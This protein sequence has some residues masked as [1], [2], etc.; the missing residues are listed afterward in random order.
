MRKSIKTRTVLFTAAALAAAVALGV[1]ARVAA[2]SAPVAA[3]T[4]T[5]GL[6]ADAGRQRRWAIILET[7]IRQG[8]LSAAAPASTTI[9]TGDWTVTVSGASAAG[10][11]V[12]CQLDKAH[13]VGSGFGTVDAKDLAQLEQNLGK[14]FWVTYQRDGAAK[15]LHFPREMGDDV[16]NFLELLVTGSE[17]VHATQP[18]P[19]W[20]ATERDGAG[21]YFAAYQQPSSSQ[22][23]KR[24]LRYV[25]LD[26]VAASGPAPIGVS[27]ENAETRFTLDQDGLVSEL[28]GHESSSLDSKMGA[29]ALGVEITLQMQRALA[30]NDRSLIGSLDRARAG[31]DSGPVVTQRA[32]AE[33]LQARYDTRLIKDL[34]LH[35]V[36]EGLASGHPDDRTEPALEAIFRRRPSDIPAALA[37]VRQASPGAAKAVLQALGVAGTDAAQS[38]LG[39]VATDGHA[40]AGLRVAA[41]GGFVQTKRPSAA[42]ISTLVGLMDSTEPGIQ[43][44]AL[45]MAGSVGSSGHDDDPAGTARIEAELLGRYAR[46]SGP[47][48]LDLLAA[49]GNLATPAIVTPI[50]QALNNS[51]ADLRASAV[52]ALRKVKDPAAERLISATILGDHDPGV[53]AAAIFAT[54]FRPIGTFVEPLTR[55]V[56]TDPVDYVRT[57]AIN[58]VANHIDASPL[59][60]AALVAAATDD[61]K[62]GIRRLAR[63]ALRPRAALQPVR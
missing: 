5:V 45:Y 59:I 11:E 56:R 54:T 1:R 50:A 40:P 36:L 46:C 19:Q 21:T 42:T 62:P 47:L 18:S 38:A 39:A 14:R 32:P 9:L 23:I 28:H 33:E 31:L 20:T 49:L 26:G 13:I 48:C 44:Q 53:R 17:L 58:S 3:A 60:Q 22:I 29:P 2:S 10:T 7:K 12:A 24:K 35:Q 43:R 27:I 37:F 25:S 16:R 8:D 51:P 63:Q 34:T 52:R 15:L 57:A 41:L 30:A 55:A 61:V 6:S 4:T